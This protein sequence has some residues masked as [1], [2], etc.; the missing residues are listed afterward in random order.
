MG[1]KC[2]ITGPFE[3]PRRETIATRGAG[4]LDLVS[5]SKKKVGHEP[6]GK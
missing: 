2:T 1:L 6:Q 3:S 5:S 4:M